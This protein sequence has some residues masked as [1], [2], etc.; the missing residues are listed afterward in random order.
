VRLGDN[1]LRQGCTLSPILYLL[2]LDTLKSDHR[3]FCMPQWDND[4]IK[5]VFDSGFNKDDSHGLLNIEILVFVDD[6]ILLANN[7]AHMQELLNHY[8]AFTKKW[9]IRVNASKCAI[10]PMSPHCTIKYSEE[11][12]LEDTLNM[13]PPWKLQGTTVNTKRKHKYLGILLSAEISFKGVISERDA[14]VIQLKS[15]VI[16]VRETMGESMAM[17]Y[18]D[19][20]L[21]PMILYG[22]ELITTPANKLM[23]WQ[24]SLCSAALGIER[25]EKSDGFSGSEPARMCV[26]GDHTLR[27]WAFEVGMQSLR[28]RKTLQTSSTTLPGKIYQELLNSKE[29]KRKKFKTNLHRSGKHIDSVSIAIQTNFLTC[30]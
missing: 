17:L 7:V 27:N 9:R 4:F 16:A 21:K 6:T 10:L 30:K 2:I 28:T 23:G 14:M 29:G 18:I 1:G 24:N 13:A 26:I 5:V 3:K 12:G 19:T 8:A 15:K 22:M 20:V 11:E 25:R